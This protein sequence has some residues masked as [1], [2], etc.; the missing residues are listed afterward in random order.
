L[1]AT[2]QNHLVADYIAAQV[3]HEQADERGTHE[4]QARAWCHWKAYME[5]IGIK[6]NDYLKTFTQEQ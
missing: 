2:Q 5:S 6:D 4:K 3:A 1:T